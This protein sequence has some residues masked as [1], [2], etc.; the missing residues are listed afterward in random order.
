MR[1]QH[2]LGPS[3]AVAP[4]KLRARYRLIPAPWVPNLSIYDVNCQAQSRDA[5]HHHEKCNNEAKT[6]VYLRQFPANPA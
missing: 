5:P 3:G 4:R 6:L 1:V 2:R